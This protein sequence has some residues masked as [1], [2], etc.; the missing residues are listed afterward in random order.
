MARMYVVLTLL[1]IL[2]LL[3]IGQVV[4]IHFTEGSEL[5]EQGESQARAI[6]TIPAM[7][8][9][10]VDQSGHIL[11]VNTARYD[12]ALD[13]TVKGFTSHVRASFFE[14]LQRLTGTSSATFYQ[15]LRRSPSRQYVRLLRNVDERVKDEIVTWNIPGLLIDT[16]FAR[17]YNYGTL[18]SHVLGH[19]D[20]DRNGIAG[21]ELAYNDYL[22]GRD[23]RRA[24]QRD[25][26]GRVRAMA[27]GRVEP[28]EHGQTIVLT[29]DLV[30]QTILEQELA[31]GVAES[32]AEWGTAIA[33]DPHTGAILGM[34]NV[35][36]YNPNRPTAAPVEA[37]RNRAITDR[38][39]PGSTFKLVPAVAAIEQGIVTLEDSVET[40]K[41]WAVFG[42]RTMKDTH[43][44]GTIPFRT[45]IAKSSNIGVAK[46]ALKMEAGVFY[47]YARNLGF[48]QPTWI[49]LPGEVSGTLKK[50]KD[51]SG[52]TFP[53]MS[54]GYEVDATPM[55]ILTAYAALANGG[56]LV[57]PYIVAE[58]RDIT[59]KTVWRARQD[60]VR[61]A[62]KQK[63]ARALLPAF[64]EVVQ[65]GTA[66]RAKIDG[67][68][69]AGKTG[70]A[71]VAAGGSYNRRTYRAS[72]AGFFPAEQPEVVML[73]VLGKPQTSG[74]GGVVAAPIFREIAA[75]WLSTF[76]QIAEQ[77]APVDALP[78]V[79]EVP[80]PDVAGQPAVVAAQQLRAAGQRVRMRAATGQERV[81]EQDPPFETAMR[82]GGRVR[83]SVEETASDSVRVM[84]DVRGLSARQAVLWLSQQGVK[85]TVKGT[86]TVQRQST[87]AGQPLPA[88]AVLQCI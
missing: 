79:V 20:T 82:T 36:T 24:L 51:W 25:R 28:P 88:E 34:A 18:A 31:K 10:I 5:R 75:R 29:L 56:L 1:S 43:G 40:G 84:P 55:Q 39:E 42:R 81:V 72:F 21:I 7:R 47:Q 62:F 63:T 19:V 15:K 70:T 59:G 45:V 68:R 17:R 61:R 6:D 66:T 14:K 32:G 57:Q 3:V 65:E 37:Q 44:Y 49:D 54:H 16:H 67:L 53:W 76:P 60:S 30:R 74:Y 26:R 13:P 41:G 38:I 50:P 8:G 46:T 69:V 11:A 80:L 77:M 22:T 48:G 9:T 85:V 71:Q 12:I 27:A 86:G 73:I 4:R 58:R 64:E 23:G 2:P 33:M 87:K 35:P 78:E 52:T 83:L